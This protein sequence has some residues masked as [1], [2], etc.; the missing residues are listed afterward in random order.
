MIFIYFKIYIK[1][2][3]YAPI[4]KKRFMCVND[5]KVSL[6]INK[7]KKKSN[8]KNIFEIYIFLRFFTK[9]VHIR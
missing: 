2:R 6:K 8:H 9:K 5:I 4:P 7:I 1:I 3:N